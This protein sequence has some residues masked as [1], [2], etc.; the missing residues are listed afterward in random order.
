MRDGISLP[1]IGSPK[2]EPEAP[3]PPSGAS[4]LV[5]LI[6]CKKGAGR[7]RLAGNPNHQVALQ[8]AVLAPLPAAL[9]RAP[10]PS[11]SAGSPRS[12]VG[13][14]RASSLAGA[15]FREKWTVSGLPRWVPEFLQQTGHR[16]SARRAQVRIEDISKMAVCREDGKSSRDRYRCQSRPLGPCWGTLP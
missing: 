13:H 6:P 7:S 12:P 3:A 14:G 2:T 4:S 1:I 16:T 5:F 10:H 8:I 9:P 11:A 15:G